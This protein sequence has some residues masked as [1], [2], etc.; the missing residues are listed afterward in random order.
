MYMTRDRRLYSG[1]RAC[2]RQTSDR[3]RCTRALRC[4]PVCRDENAEGDSGRD[5]CLGTAIPTDPLNAAAAVVGFR[6]RFSTTRLC[7]VVATHTR[8]SSAGP[9]SEPRTRMVLL[10]EFDPWTLR[11]TG[12]VSLL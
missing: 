11:W 8:R 7:W 10:F 1:L 9:D 2:G 3:P 12:N 5:G 6:C 4:A